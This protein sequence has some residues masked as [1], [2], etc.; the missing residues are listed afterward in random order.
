MAAFLLRR[1][2]IAQREQA[3]KQKLQKEIELN[4]LKE[5][6]NPHFLFN[7]LNSIYSLDCL[8]SSSKDYIPCGDLLIRATSSTNASAGVGLLLIKGESYVCVFWSN[9]SSSA[10]TT[11]LNS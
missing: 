11:T 9:Y 3:E 6:V 2:I 4:Y 5:Q 1:N 8:K 7:S 10:S